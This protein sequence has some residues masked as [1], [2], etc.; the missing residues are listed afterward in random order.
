MSRE[1]RVGIVGAGPFGT[2]LAN[3][4]GSSG[5]P[6]TLFTLDQQVVTAI[7]AT[8]ENPRTGGISLPPSVSATDDPRQ[9]SNDARFIIIAVSSTE[10]RRRLHLL[11]DHLN[12]QHIVVHA[13]GALA[14]PD[15]TRVSQVIEEETPVLRIGALAGPA[16]WRDLV[17]G[18][19]S[20]MVVASAFDE[21][22]REARRLLS[23][24]PTL[25]LYSGHD[26]I[27]VEMAA[28]LSCAYTVA[29]GV[30]DGLGL[31][32]GPRAVLITRALAEASRLGRAAGASDKT[33]TGLAGLGN[34]LVRIQSE[35]SADYLAGRELAESDAVSA[36]TEG[37]RA[38]LAGVRLAR[39]AGQRAPVL[40]AI[41]AVLQGELSARE[42]AVAAADT[43]ADEE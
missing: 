20:S 23:V 22:T 35:H 32:P 8:R 26:L 6:V 1:H 36:P 34:L 10:V 38:A 9:F 28:A 24:P 21:V 13:I 29:V 25:R 2:A 30:S 17:S 19:F 39:R 12:G 42:A 31:G 40:S 27:G 16:L 3:L 41:A 5:R 18:R 7:R 14:S 43:V 15:D 4:L 11:G 33:F 37:T